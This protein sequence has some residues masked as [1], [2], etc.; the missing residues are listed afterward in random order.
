MI[1]LTCS[2]FDYIIPRTWAHK[3]FYWTLRTCSQHFHLLPFW[4]THI[5]SFIQK[6]TNLSFLD[7]V[8]SFTGNFEIVL[9]FFCSFTL[10]NLV[11]FSSAN[12]IVQLTHRSSISLNYILL[13][14]C[15]VKR[16]WIKGLV[17]NIL[18]IESKNWLWS[19]FDE[20]SCLEIVWGNKTSKFVFPMRVVMTIEVRVCCLKSVHL[21]GEHQGCDSSPYIFVHR[22]VKY[23]KC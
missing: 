20:Y 14:L 19:F 7:F 22:V 1:F 3:W 10:W 5:H 13:F 8:G 21:E 6:W 12:C 9:H 16:S 15:N 11:I 23:F 17:C 4:T 18:S 2:P